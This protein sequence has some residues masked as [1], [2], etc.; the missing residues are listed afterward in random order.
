MRAGAQEEKAMT[1]GV[2]DR[3]S[4]QPATHQPGWLAS[5]AD[6]L[7]EDWSIVTS[8]AGWVYPARVE[9]LVEP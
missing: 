1:W 4:W 3:V 6:M 7:A 9:K 2:W 5:Q 8:P